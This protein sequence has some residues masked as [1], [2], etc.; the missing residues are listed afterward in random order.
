MHIAS[1]KTCLFSNIGRICRFFAV[2]LSPQFGA[3]NKKAGA[4][5]P[6]FSQ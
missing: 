4:S 5:A 6:A 3:E 1:G 2:F